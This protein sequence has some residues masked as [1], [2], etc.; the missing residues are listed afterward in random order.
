MNEPKS[1]RPDVPI[2]SLQWGWTPR[3]YEAIGAKADELFQQIGSVER[4]SVTNTVLRE[5]I[6][7]LLWVLGCPKQ[8]ELLLDETSLKLLE[9]D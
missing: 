1:L 5:R 7:A 6:V 8:T 4:A 2:S 9:W 3:T